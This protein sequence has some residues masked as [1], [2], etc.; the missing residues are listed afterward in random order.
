MRDKGLEAWKKEWRN[1]LVCKGMKRFMP[2]IDESA[3][4]IVRDLSKQDATLF[5]GIVMGHNRLG[6]H[7]AKMG[8]VVDSLCRLCSSKAE[9]SAHLVFDCEK[10]TEDIALA[11]FSDTAGKAK[12]E[13]I[14]R[15]AKDHLAALFG[16]PQPLGT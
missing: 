14:L 7:M 8:G 5:V 6:L 15:F 13:K 12:F 2:D 3:A 9:T 4:Q 11:G 1:P 16:P 10:L